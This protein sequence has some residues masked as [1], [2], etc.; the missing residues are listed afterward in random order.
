MNC[1]SEQEILKELQPIVE[2][3][4]VWISI[5]MNQVKYDNKKCREMHGLGCAASYMSHLIASSPDLIIYIKEKALYKKPD[6][7]SFLVMRVTC[8]GSMF[9]V[10]MMNNAL[11]AGR[12]LF[13]RSGFIGRVFRAD[14]RKEK[15]DKQEVEDEVEDEKTYKSTARLEH[16]ATSVRSSS[17]NFFPISHPISNF[18]TYTPNVGAQM[19]STISTDE[20]LNSVEQSVFEIPANVDSPM[21]TYLQHQQEVGRKRKKVPRQQS[22]MHRNFLNFRKQKILP[23]EVE[24]GIEGTHFELRKPTRPG[25]YIVSITIVCHLNPQHRVYKVESFRHLDWRQFFR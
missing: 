20:D 21:T 22:M 15:T 18:P 12:R 25:S 3:D 5:W 19:N 16:D 13:S 4:V 6:D 17:T 7:S 10:V 8:T 9:L 24:V 2:P 11:N 14:L 23:E 1:V